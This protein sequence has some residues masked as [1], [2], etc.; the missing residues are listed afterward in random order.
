[1]NKDHS[2]SPVVNYLFRNRGH[3]YFN[4]KKMRKKVEKYTVYIF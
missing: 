1:M 4:I 3:F 2:D